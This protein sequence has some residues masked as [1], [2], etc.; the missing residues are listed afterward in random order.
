ML[1]E[2]TE[3]YLKLYQQFNLHKVADNV[4]S[5]H[6]I[7]Q[8]KLNVQ[9][10]V[11]LEFPPLTASL[12]T[13]SDSD[14]ED[15]KA[16]EGLIWK[17]LLDFAEYPHLF[18]PAIM[19]SDIEQGKLGNCGFAA[20]LTAISVYPELIKK[21]FLFPTNKV[22][23]IG[24]YE[25]RLCHNG[26]WREYTIDDL[27]PCNYYGTPAFTKHENG[28][29]LWVSLIEKCA[30]KSYGGYDRLIAFCKLN[31]FNDLTGCPVEQIDFDIFDNGNV[32]WKYLL[33][34]TANKYTAMT[35]AATIER[36]KKPISDLG[37]NG[38][39][40]FTFLKAVQVESIRLI[41]IRNPHGKCVDVKDRWKGKYSRY[42]Y[43]SEWTQT[44]T[45]II[46]PGLD[47][48]DGTLWMEFN[49]F[50]QYFRSASLCHL[51]CLDKTYKILRINTKIIYNYDKS[52]NVEDVLYPKCILDLTGSHSGDSAMDIEWVGLQQENLLSQF[53]KFYE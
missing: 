12:M 37:I 32:L 50:Q 1:G 8:N 25:L 30:A 10:F 39:H 15:K 16:F 17:R 19:L 9:C 42:N 49:D 27:I 4:S 51:L 33:E 18:G 22:S 13:K 34:W 47:A 5:L 35:L 7:L 23:S 53:S 3:K 52:S 45:E 48:N 2:A 28:N 14:F 11:D 24:L 38:N 29:I 36:S 43:H 20:S 44:L 40:A 6:N 26:I 21:L 46:R 31:A 41:Q